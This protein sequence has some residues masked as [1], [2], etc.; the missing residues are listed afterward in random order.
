MYL[1]IISKSQKGF[2]KN[3]NFADIIRNINDIINFARV[4]GTSGLVASLHFRKAY[5]SGASRETIY[6]I[7]R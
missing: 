5:D 3:H 7:A 1:N 4:S 2:M 6:L